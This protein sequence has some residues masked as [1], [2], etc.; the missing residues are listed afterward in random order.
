MR[1]VISI[2]SKL[3]YLLLA[4]IILVIVLVGFSLDL[5][6]K[7]FYQNEAGNDFQRLFSEVSEQLQENEKSITD[8]ANL[9]AS[10]NE[11]IATVNMVHRYSDPRKYQP[12][13]FDPEKRSLAEEL[14]EEARSGNIDEIAIYAATGALV[15]FFSDGEDKNKE[16][17]GYISYQ[18]GKPIIY[19]ARSPLKSKWKESPL[20]DTI[21]LFFDPNKLNSDGSHY[22]HYNNG[23][24]LH[25]HASIQRNYPDGSKVTVGYVITKK[26]IT[27]TFVDEI[28]RKTG[29]DFAILLQRGHRIGGLEEISPK[30]LNLEDTQSDKTSSPMPFVRHNLENYFA[31]TSR[32][33]LIDQTALLLAAVPKHVVNIAIGNAQSLVVM[34]LLASAIII[35]PIGIAVANRTISRPL[36]QLTEGVGAVQKGDYGTRISFSSHDELDSLARA[37]N[38]MSSSIHEREEEL[39]ESE[40]K[41]RNLVDNLPQ[42]IFFKNRDFNYVSC[43]RHYAEELGIDPEEIVGKNDFDFFSEKYALKYRH[44][45][46]RIMKNGVMEELEEPY[47]SEK[48]RGTIQTVKTP[49]RDSEGS[50]VGILGIFW[51]ITDKK[52]AETRLRQSAAVFE[53]TADGVIITDADIKIIAVNRTF[54]EITGYSEGEALGKK[55]S[56]RRS[57]RQ[58]EEFYRNMWDEIKSEGRWKGEIWNRRKS[59]EVYP[60]WMTISTVKDTEGRVTNYVSVFSDITNVKRT[61]M[62]LD[63]MAHHDPLTDLPNRTLLDDRLEQAISRARRHRTGVA[64]LFIDLDRFK[65]VNDSLGHP[66]GDLL[67][68]DVAKRLQS[69]LREEDT[70]ARLGGDEF[71]VLVE[72]LTKPEMAEAVA[73][74]MLKTIARPFSIQ[75]HELYI[76]ASVGISIFPDDGT[77]AETLIKYADAAMYRAKEHGRNTYEF[78]TQ[79]L[80]KSALERLELESALR[81]AIERDEMEVYYQP[82]LDFASG[83]FIGA[84]ALLRW[85]HPEHGL[86]PPDKFIPLAEESGIITDI[87]EWV[88]RNA[89]QQAFVWSQ[90]FSCFK[91]LAVNLSGV[92]VQRGDVVDT[93]G[94]ILKQTGLPAEMLELEITESVLMQYPEVATETLGGLREL[95]IELAIDD[96]GTGYSS[97][98]YLKRFPLQILKID[99]SFIMGIPSD[100]NDTEITRAVIAMAKS[101]HLT[102]IAEGVENDEQEQFLIR[103]G[104]DIGQGYYYSQAISADEFSRLMAE[105]TGLCQT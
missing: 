79:E 93:I 77:D 104:C 67:L 9:L 4:T 45:D 65:N 26:F 51:D 86:V 2:K 62:Q 76:G 12:L 24:L 18:Q 23:V 21:P 6:I 95:G 28:K 10:R 54:T 58:N 31:A 91:R 89:C 39:V 19:S 5:L 17:R 78:Y 56:F 13:I 66:T 47:E 85:H 105:K 74:K 52:E 64:I 103:E 43:N 82:Q 30:M 83:R 1:R 50:I 57:E 60:E 42:S 27:R 29:V 20:P 35:L 33:E 88:L 15:S 97:L 16:A 70:L 34:V 3:T 94:E 44:D 69:V 96:F 7:Q 8:H 14:R 73:A 53:S 37:F 11:I 25:H 36:A 40:N 63:H 84:E 100:A 72:E 99:R 48:T 98:S 92:Q 49:I 61:Q 90:Q 102:I 41:Y 71:I 22:N 68:Q 101:L 87:G 59:G 55:P 81:R 46:A 75:G 32:L 38:N 80:T